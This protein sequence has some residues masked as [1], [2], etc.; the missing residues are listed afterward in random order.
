LSHIILHIVCGIVVSFQDARITLTKPIN[1]GGGSIMKKRFFM[2]V[3]IATLMVFLAAPALAEGDNYLSNKVG[4]GYQGMI[5]GSLINGISVRGWIG[6]NF[7]LEGSFS[8]GGIGVEID[9]H[10]LADA[11][12]T[13]FE[14]KA[15]YA[16]IVKSNSRFYVGA[17]AGYGMIDVDFFEENMLDDDLWTLGAFVGSEWSWSEIPELGFNFDVGYNYIMFDTDIPDGGPEIELD[18][19]GIAATFGIHYYF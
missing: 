10:D 7:G 15:M 16:F 12:L 18:L 8:Y 14:A 4:V 11:D 3:A 19:D 13:L 9:G 6:D 1:D 2:C 5:A 17:K